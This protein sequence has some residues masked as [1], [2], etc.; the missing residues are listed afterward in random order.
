MITEQRYSVLDET[1]FETF[2]ALCTEFRYIECT[3]GIDIEKHDDRNY[4]SKTWGIVGFII[5]KMKRF[6]AT[7]AKVSRSTPMYS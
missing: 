5:I 3:D 1:T 2:N 4:S 6:H 7:M